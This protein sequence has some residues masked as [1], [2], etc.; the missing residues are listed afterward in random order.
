[1]EY[2]QSPIKA[3]REKCLDCCCGSM[4]EV[5]DCPC[6]RCPIYPFRLGKNPFRQKREMTEEQKKALVDRL[7]E[8]RKNSTNSEEN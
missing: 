6:K 4:T 7:S 5:K 1:M 8:G 2:K 3:I